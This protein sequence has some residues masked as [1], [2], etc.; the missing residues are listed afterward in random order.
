MTVTIGLPIGTE[1]EAR[2]VGLKQGV[3]EV[4]VSIRP[5]AE[6]AVRAWGRLRP[7]A[8]HRQQRGRASRASWQDRA[9]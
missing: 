1:P 8:G 6:L 4:E 9:G 2:H 5:A 3:A 7:V